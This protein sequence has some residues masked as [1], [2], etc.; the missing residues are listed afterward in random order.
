LTPEEFPILPW[1]GTPGNEEAIKGIW[2]CGFN[3]AG[4][5]SP[6]DV[7]VAA[8]L[9]MKCIVRDR[10]LYSG[11]DDTSLTG[12]EIA[13]R[14]KDFCAPLLEHPGV[15]G[16]YLKDEPSAGLF[17]SLARW[18]AALKAE[19]PDALNYINLLPNYA[20]PE[21]LGTET[22]EE[23]LEKFV[24]TVKPSYISYDHYALMDDGSLRHGYFQNLESVRR[25][26][27]RHDLP[28]WN[29]VL[30]NSH[31]R[32]ADPTLDG[33]RFQVYTTLAYGGR[34][35]SYFTYFISATGNY[36]LSPID[37]FG[38]KTPT[39]DML[40]NVNLQIHKLGPTYLKLKS[41]NVFHHP[42]VPEGCG[43]IETSRHIAVINGGDFVVGEF[44]DNDGNPF[45][46]VVNKDLHFSTA[47][48]VKFKQEGELMITNAYTGRTHSWGREQDWLAPGQGM[49][50]SV[51][52]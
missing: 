3:L 14:V 18:S 31:F 40:R 37:Q 9:G 11:I 35:I 5:M 30:S 13:K 12:D 39:W 27:L 36:R 51:K 10:R 7:D 48:D 19:A 46:M 47:F 42:E 4:F 41:I 32:Y 22:Y 50:L 26:S 29:I 38:N 43:G 49:L 28:F 17:P 34:G 33:L 25:V 23:H 45:V 24:E 6:N 1:S 16:Y 44:F 21:Q 2:E 52:K 15:F 8:K 20:S